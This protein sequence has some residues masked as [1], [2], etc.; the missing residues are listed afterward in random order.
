MKTLDTLAKLAT[1]I[2]AA[3]TLWDVIDERQTKNRLGR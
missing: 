3:V 1:I 2:L